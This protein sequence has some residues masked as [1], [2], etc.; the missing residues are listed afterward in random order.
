MNID[1]SKLSAKELFEL[2]H[3]KELEEQRQAELHERMTRLRQQQEDLV[4]E[5]KAQLTKL[6]KEIKHLQQQRDRL[7]EAHDLDLAKLEGELESTDRQ[8]TSPPAATKPA[9]SPP[10]PETA[11]A[12]GGD[13]PESANPGDPDTLFEQIRELMRGR[14]YISETLLKEKLRGKGNT[15]VNLGKALEQLVKDRRLIR[16]SGGSYVLGK[17]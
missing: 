8:L 9:Q 11:P 5:F 13:K 4:A 17:K 15:G 6:D 1:I 3:Q 10:A 7:V 12:Q 14:E 2:A 16:K